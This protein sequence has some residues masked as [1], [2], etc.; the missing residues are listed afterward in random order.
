MF[1]VANSPIDLLS[2]KA[3]RVSKNG[4][5]GIARKTTLVANLN[6]IGGKFNNY[7]FST[8]GMGQ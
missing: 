4:K 3:V 5:W 6:L 2:Y 7:F 8:K 1:P